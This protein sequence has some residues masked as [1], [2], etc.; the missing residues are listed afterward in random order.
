MICPADEVAL[1]EVVR[2]AQAPLLIQ[3]NGTKAAMLRPV[4][5]VQAP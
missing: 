3:G 2:A 1:A 5:A 4:Q